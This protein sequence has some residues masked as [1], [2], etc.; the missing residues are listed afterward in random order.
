ML[1]VEISRIPPEG[2][3]LD[4][5]LTPG[6]VHVEGE[7]TFELLPGGHLEAHVEKGDEDSVHVRG[8]LSARLQM[9]C[10]RCLE[11]FVF[12]V[13]QALDLFY[14]PQRAAP[15]PEE[16]EEVE[17]ADRDMVIAYYRGGRLDLGDMMREQLF[18]GIPMKR[19]CRESCAG[20][21]PSCGANRNVT[22]CECKAEDVDPRLAPL[23]DL[24]GK[25]SS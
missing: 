12:P 4:S 25:R 18:L 14:L 5:E 22:P 23:K 3:D 24:L 7:D 16:E 6:E 13:D 9:Q 10:G 21:C 15:Q 1:I 19:L 2:I 20:L 8:H 11:P 17:L